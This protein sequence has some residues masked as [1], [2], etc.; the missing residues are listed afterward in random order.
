M[1]ASFTHVT[2]ALRAAS[3]V[4]FMSLAK[5]S[6]ATVQFKQ[7]RAPGGTA[8]GQPQRSQTASSFIAFWQWLQKTLDHIFHNIHRLSGH[9]ILIAFIAFIRF[10]YLSCFLSLTFFARRSFVC[11]PMP[12]LRPMRHCRSRNCSSSLLLLLLQWLQPHQKK[13]NFLPSLTHVNWPRMMMTRLLFLDLAYHWL[14]VSESF[15]CRQKTSAIPGF[16]LSNAG[17]AN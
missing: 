16:L 9:Y 12:Q 6:F 10:L 5:E 17:S 8:S 3:I 14:C 13:E 7:M 4:S 15:L 1:L 2:H 11:L